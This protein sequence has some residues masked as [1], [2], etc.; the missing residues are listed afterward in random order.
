MEYYNF[1]DHVRGEFYIG[2][3]FGKHRDHSVLA[4]VECKDGLLLLRYCY[5]FQL[6]TPYAAVI[7]HTKVLCD[8]WTSVR[9][10]YL[11]RTGLGDYIVEDSKNAGIP[12]VE[13]I[14]F[15]EA[16]KEEMTT[17]LKQHMLE[18]KFW[19]PFDEG[20]INELNVERFELD[21]TGKIRL[22]HPEGTNDDR[23]WAVA[24]SVYTAT[25]GR[26]PVNRPLAT[27]F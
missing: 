1:E 13:G 17:A 9:S 5:Q 10:A 4:V 20:L 15:T 11:D 21:K 25:I 2:E 6:K 12:N 16:R 24:L 18:G 8:R 27:S 14:N 26:Q 23:F 7:G 22:S 3:D 19:F